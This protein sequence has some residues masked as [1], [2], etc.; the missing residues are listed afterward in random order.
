MIITSQKMKKTCF[1]LFVFITLSLS[2]ESFSQSSVSKDETVM[3]PDG[4]AFPFW[5]DQT[6]Y[7]NIY[8]VDQNHPEA[9]DQNP[10]TEDN[11]FLT[12]NQ[13]A[14]VLKP[15]EKVIIKKGIY[16][17]N[18]MP[19]RGGNDPKSM[20]CY[21]AMPGTILSGSDVLKEKWIISKTPYNPSQVF[22]N[23][24]WMTDV[25]A[26]Y[27]NEPNPFLMQNA[28][29]GE[30]KIMPWAINWTHKIPYILVRGIIFQD[31]KRMTQLAQYEDVVKLPGSYWV[32]T[33]GSDKFAFRIHIHPFDFRDP[34]EQMME[35]TTRQSPFNPRI[36]GLNFIRVKGFTIEQVGNGFQRTGKGALSTF[37]GRNW[38]IEDNNIRKINSVGI[39]IGA[40][41]NEHFSEGTRE[42]LETITGRHIVRNNTVHDCG[43]GGIQGLINIECLVEN[44]FL[45]DIGWQEAEFYWETAAI[46][47]LN[48]TSCLIRKNHIKDVVAAD[49]IWL[50]YTNIN[51]RVTQNLIYN[52]HCNQGAVF[53]EASYRPVLVDNNLI[54]NCWKNS[55]YQHDCDSVIMLHNIVGQNTRGNAIMMTLNKGRKKSASEF[56]SAKNNTILFNLLIDNNRPFSYSDTI[57]ISDYNVISGGKELFDWDSWHKKGFDKNSKLIKVNASFDPQNLIFK[58]KASGSLPRAERLWYINED[59]I[60]RKYD[61]KTITPG[62]LKNNGTEILDLS[63]HFRNVNGE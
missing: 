15:G 46:K 14:K 30:M 8:Y 20:I 12:I 31:G 59:L 11:P 60:G 47:L 32:D 56:F 22:S 2:V 51:S 40:R 10:G 18:V 49:G 43:T 17:E 34:N 44:N 53:I 25:P 29:E 48:T 28:D 16:R 39:E 61:N 42:E 27:F 19:A 37:G 24:M 3:L 58:V 50:D 7:A 52:V 5:D 57:N 26:S 54:W 9:S 63:R 36:K 55:L 1:L 45:Y 33:A 4:T 6:V 41:T 35:I 21:E 38:I 62:C 23:N 13:A